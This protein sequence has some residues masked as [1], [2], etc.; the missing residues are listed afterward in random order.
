MAIVLSRLVKSCMLDDTVD[1]SHDQSTLVKVAT[2]GLTELKP[3]LL[4]CQGRKSHHETEKTG[5]STYLI[6]ISAL[7]L[8]LCGDI[9]A[10]P[11]PNNDSTIYLC[12]C[13]ELRVSW[14]AQAVCCDGCDLWYHQSCLLIPSGEFKDLELDNAIWLC[15]KCDSKNLIST[16]TFHSFEL[17]N[18]FEL[19]SHSS[20]QNISASTLQSPTLETFIPPRHSSPR[21][22]PEQ[23]HDHTRTLGQSPA[24]DSSLSSKDYGL[25]ARNDNLRTLIVNCNSIQG[26]TSEFKTA[27]HYIRPDI[28]LGCESKLSPDVLDAEIFPPGY[29]ALRKDRKRGGGGVFIL[30]KSCFTVSRV[31]TSLLHNSSEQIWARISLK[32][33]KDLFVGC[34]YRPPRVTEL[35]FKELNEVLN[36]GLK[37]KDKTIILGGDFNTR[38]IDWDSQSLSGDCALPGV[39]E[40]LIQLSNDNGLVQLRICSSPINQA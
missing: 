24:S 7:T 10:N 31:D 37:I 14:S 13:C 30:T 32:N 9:Q 25:P 1:D 5:L 21:K 36:R 17:S 3:S 8:L 4:H 23:R 6:N 18:S 39:C 12:G 28:I 40:E 33:A 26:K 2:S 11:G 15:C 35:P 20:R 38:G 16:F 29:V 34:F 19:L 27:V 22:S